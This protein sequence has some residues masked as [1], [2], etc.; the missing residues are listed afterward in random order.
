MFV[1]ATLLL[2]EMGRG[3]GF[4]PGAWWPIFPIF[5]LLL[6]TVVVF[7]VFRSRRAWWRQS[8]GPSAESVL[9]ERYARGEIDEDEYRARLSVLKEGRS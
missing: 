6:A 9:S 7:A 4:G 8:A 3:Y 2:A 5:W 1:A